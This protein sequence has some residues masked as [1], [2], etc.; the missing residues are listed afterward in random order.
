VR[1]VILGTG[2]GVGKTYFTAA[3]ARSL[4]TE[5]PGSVLALKPVETGVARDRSG[6][7]ARA[8]DAHRLEAATPGAP[9]RRP[10]PLYAF[11]EPLSPHLAA[12]RE[13]RRVSLN[14]VAQWAIR[15]SALHDV[16]CISLIE[17]AGGAFSPVTARATNF[18]LAL[19]LEPAVWILVGTD[20]LGTLHDVR[21]TLLAMEKSGRAP[22]HLVL[23]A[24]RTPDPST[25][26]NAA[27][28]ARV[29]L[30]RPIAVLDRN[31]P[32]GH[33]LRSLVRALRV[34]DSGLRSGR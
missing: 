22:N 6:A 26:S 18:D 23:S 30:P 24:A 12:R 5:M 25:G 7:P 13:G 17:T 3:L 1:V 34:E 31:D 19:R 4:A 28:L 2:T 27:E 16:P 11:K 8:S 10:H 21:A 14:R 32:G 29:G 20:A 15:D 9:R 33:S